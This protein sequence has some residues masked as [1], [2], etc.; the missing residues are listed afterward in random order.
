[1]S[2]KR[3][4]TLSIEYALLGFLQE[5]SLHGYEM[6]QHL[7]AAQTL[8]FVWHLKQA[9]LYALLAKLEANGLI[10][11][12]VIPQDDRPSKRLLHLTNT[13]RSAFK[14]WVQTPVH[15]G[16]DLRIEFL[17]K[18]FW[19]QQLGVPAVQ[20][21]IAAQ[22]AACQGWLDEFRAEAKGLA[23]ARP[24]EWLVLE[25]RIGQIEAMLQWLNTCAA[26]LMHDPRHS[27]S[28][29]LESQ[30]DNPDEF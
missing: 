30:P 4:A 28:Q 14:T 23:S 13:G 9:H 5:Q 17:A 19:A 10:T 11:A 2:P 22:H 20:R 25:F 1:M 15:H 16:R 26:V 3:S 6:H 24:Y 12:E 8:G 27:N 29:G 21:L 7:Q 18:L